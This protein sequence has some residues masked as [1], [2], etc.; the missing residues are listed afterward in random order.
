[1]RHGVIQLEMA[2]NVVAVTMC[3]DRGHGLGEEVSHFI[4]EA[5]DAHSC[6]DHEFAIAP[7]NMPDVAPPH[8]RPQPVCVEVFALM[9]TETSTQTLWGGA[10]L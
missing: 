7:S 10:H 4:D 5:G 1:M 2:A 9:S 6:V 3:G 8:Q